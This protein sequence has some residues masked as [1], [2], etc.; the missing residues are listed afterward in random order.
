MSTPAPEPRPPIERTAYPHWEQ[1]QIRW[2]DMD[3]MGHINNA[4]V[5]TYFEQSRIGLITPLLARFDHPGLNIV[6]ARSTID[7]LREF[8]YPGVAD[9]GTRLA[10]IG[11][12]SFAFDSAIFLAGVCVATCTATAV[13]FDTVGRHSVAPPA[14]VRAALAALG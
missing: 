14:D 9:V 12:K 4:V 2:G 13:F 11:A 10:R 3:A 5:A 6:L 8:H 7:F 1:V